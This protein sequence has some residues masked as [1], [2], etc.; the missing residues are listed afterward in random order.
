MQHS[1][2]GAGVIVN[3]PGDVLTAL[4]VVA[5]GGRIEVQFADGTVA[6]ARV[7]SRQ[8]ENDIAVLAPDRLPQVVVPAVL[9]GRRTSATRC[10]RWATRSACA[11]R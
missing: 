8:P 7:V 4:H 5:G 11:A 10:S 6:T 1:E 9:G 2:L 3:A